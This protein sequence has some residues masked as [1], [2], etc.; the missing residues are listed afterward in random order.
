MV[1][2]PLVERI[3]EDLK[4]LLG[5]DKVIDDPEI[6]SLY[7]R[8]PSGISSKAMAVVFPENIREVSKIASYAY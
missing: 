1:E 7:S 4:R 6:V 5:R 3:S 2:G 8:E